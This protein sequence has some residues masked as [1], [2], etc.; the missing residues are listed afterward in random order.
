MP[1]LNSSGICKR[2]LQELL[3]LLGCLCRIVR[4]GDGDVHVVCLRKVS[5]P[6]NERFT[7]SAVSA[8]GLVQIVD[9]HIGNIKVAGMQ[10]AEEALQHV[11]IVDA[12]LLGINQADAVVHVI[13][14][15]LAV[16]DAN[17][18]A[19][20][21]GNSLV[22]GINQLLGL[23]GALQAHNNIDHRKILLCCAA[24]C[25]TIILTAKC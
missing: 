19:L 1:L 3:D 5:A 4:N 6:Q 14:Q 25:C 8:D 11:Q 24:S 20:G 15:L 12:V 17:H 22:D 18:I 2:V 13:G 16:L 7:G 21:I 9:V 23:T 10:T